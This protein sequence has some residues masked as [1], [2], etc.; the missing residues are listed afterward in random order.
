[1]KLATS[2]GDFGGYT[3]SAAEAVR[4]F[5]G[6]GFKHLDYNFYR[7]VYKGSPFMGDHWMD[8]VKAAGA[9]AE[10]LGFDFVQA[11][12]PGNNPLNPQEDWDTVVLGNVRSI[13]ACAY[14]GIPSIV[15]HSGIADKILYE[16]GKDEYF[17]VNRRFY[18][19]LRPASEK[20]NVNVLIENSARA[21]MGDRYFFM[22]GQEMIDFIDYCDMPKLHA[23]WDVG[24]ANMQDPDQYKDIMTLGNHLKGIHF[25]DNLGHT[26]DH[27]APFMGTLDV[28]SVMRGLFDC[29]YAK[30]IGILDFECD[31]ILCRAKSW[32]NYRNAFSGE[33]AKLPGPTLRMKQAAICLLYEI[34]RGILE[35][36]DC[37][38]E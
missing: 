24:H 19:A 2:I 12:S 33:A 38:E 26:D 4:A 6:T 35:A 15:V 22:T 7:E 1:M 10:K 32:P 30:E 21:N 34:G 28:D 3:K 5:E 13:E 17:E 23:C 31:N 14:L 27:M 20:Y 29:G 18:E 37:F 11:H 16:G 25:Q 9:E 36:Y 8:A